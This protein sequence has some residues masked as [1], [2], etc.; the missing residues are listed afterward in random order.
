MVPLLVPCH[1]WCGTLQNPHCS[2]IISDERKVKISSPSPVM[3]TSPYQWKFEWDENPQTNKQSLLCNMWPEVI[4]AV[5]KWPEVI[6]T[7]K[8]MTWGYQYCVRVTRGNHCCV[9]GHQRKSLQCEG[10]PEV[11]TTVWGWPMLISAAWG[12]TIGNHCCVWGDQK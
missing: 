9:K 5:W 8:M 12:V 4:T 11:I 2:M 10:W 1:S 3:V 7:V 6:T